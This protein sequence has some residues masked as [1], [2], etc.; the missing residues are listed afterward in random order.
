MKKFLV[1]ICLSSLLLTGCTHCKPII[2]TEVVEVKVPVT[3]PMDPIQIPEHPLL[4]INTLTPSD[5]KDFKKV[6][7]AYVMSL[8]RLEAHIGELETLIDGV[9]NSGKK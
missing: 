6:G 1:A 2:K 3:V 7:K 9:N 4:P 5:R 8:K